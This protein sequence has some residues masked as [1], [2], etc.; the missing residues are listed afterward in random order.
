MTDNAVEA[1]IRQALNDR[2]IFS[3]P[4]E[5]MDRTTWSEFRLTLRREDKKE[6]LAL[7]ERAEDAMRVRI[8]AEG[9]SKKRQ[10]WE[11]AKQ[12]VMGLRSYLTADSVFVRE[13]ADKLDSFGPLK[14]DLPNMEDFGK[15][16]ESHSRPV[17]EQFFLYRI[18]KEKDQRRGDGLRAVFEV[19]KVLY[20]RRTD[21]L[22]IAFFVR[23]IQSLKETVEVLKWRRS[24]A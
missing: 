7:L 19:V 16:I 14:S 6:A 2:R 12:L 22:E 20:E 13:L 21:P 24:R 8:K 4:Q 23:K 17:A 11:E 15:V 3:M 18:Q 5:I 9:D 10:S 1:A